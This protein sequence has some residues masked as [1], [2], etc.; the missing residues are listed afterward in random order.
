MT[1]KFFFFE[2]V[3]SLL[4]DR[5][6]VLGYSVAVPHLHLVF[7]KI[8]VTYISRSCLGLHMCVQCSR[9]KSNFYCRHNR[10]YT[11]QHP[12]NCEYNFNFVSSCR[13]CWAKEGL[14]G[15]LNTLATYAMSIGRTMAHLVSFVGIVELQLNMT[16]TM[17][18]FVNTMKTILIARG[19]SDE[20]EQN[21]LHRCAF[22]SS[23]AIQAEPICHRLPRIEDVPCRWGW[24]FCSPGAN[25]GTP[26]VAPGPLGHQRA[27]KCCHHCRID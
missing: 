5:S 14:I 3:V 20:S 1:Y 12:T 17:I 2:M 24:I 9:C 6:M 23:I 27:T 7:Y 18:A 10:V 21:I 4:I 19:V 26:G 15:W 11:H 22:G 13:D 16:T 8:W 25:K